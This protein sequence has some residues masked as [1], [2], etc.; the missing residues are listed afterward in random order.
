MMTESR[1]KP[2]IVDRQM[3]SCRRKSAV[4]RVRVAPGTGKIEINATPVEVLNA[5]VPVPFHLDGDNLS[6]T[7]RLTRRVL[8]LRRDAFHRVALRGDR[9]QRGIVLQP[10]EID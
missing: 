4:A 3:Q 9:R 8:D 10:V 6:E 2:R 7:T 1:S 5:S